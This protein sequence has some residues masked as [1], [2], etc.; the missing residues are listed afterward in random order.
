MRTLFLCWI[1]QKCINA[2]FAFPV[3]RTPEL[4]RKHL[5]L[6]QEEHVPRGSREFKNNFDRLY[7]TSRP[8]SSHCRFVFRR[9]HIE[10]SSLSWLMYYE[11]FL[12]QMSGQCLKLRHFRFLPCPFLSINNE[13][14]AHWT[15]TFWSSGS[16]FG[17]IKIY[18][19]LNTVTL[20]KLRVRNQ[21]HVRR[22][23]KLRN[24]CTLSVGYPERKKYLR[25]LITW[26]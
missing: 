19:S 24:A 6:K 25:K 16:S 21:E 13:L 15:H 8:S 9:S 14:P 20:I 3:W 17:Y 12:R 7:L 10:M 11:V 2:M 18:P 1:E 23:I 5:N 4:R 22:I 26:T